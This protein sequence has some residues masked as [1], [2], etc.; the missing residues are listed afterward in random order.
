[1]GKK[2]VKSKWIGR[3]NKKKKQKHEMKSKIEVY[4]FRRNNGN[5]WDKK[6]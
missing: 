1:M 3:K 5:E 6:I 4:K 2:K